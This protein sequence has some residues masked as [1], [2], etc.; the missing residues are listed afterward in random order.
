M[1]RRRVEA[2]ALAVAYF[3]FALLNVFFYI[4]QPSSFVRFMQEVPGG[5]NL[6]AGSM[7]AFFLMSNVFGLLT[8]SLMPWFLI[9]RRQRFIAACVG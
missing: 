4:L 5:Q 6:P 1:L 2:H 8:T 9:T 3:A 7:H